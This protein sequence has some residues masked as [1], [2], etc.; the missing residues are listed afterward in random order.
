MMRPLIF[1]VSLLFGALSAHA[2]SGGRVAVTCDSF[3]FSDVV[4]VELVETDLEGQLFARETLASGETR[5]LYA[6]INASDV[7]AG[8]AIRLSDWNGYTRT[9]YRS[10]AG[11]YQVVTQDE[12]S[13]A[14]SFV[15]CSER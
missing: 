4:K 5:D 12:C 2:S 1:S 6:M 15:A 7:E 8:Q 14:I 9:L 13:S 3:P 11:A 10:G